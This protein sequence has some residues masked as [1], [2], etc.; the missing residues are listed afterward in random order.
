[1]NDL[2]TTN[3]AKVLGKTSLNWHSQCRLTPKYNPAKNVNQSLFTNVKGKLAHR[4]KGNH[5]SGV[6]LSVNFCIGIVS[7]RFFRDVMGREKGIPRVDSTA[8][9]T[10][11]CSSLYVLIFS[12]QSYHKE[13]VM[14]KSPTLAA[15]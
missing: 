9:D 10:G 12:P 7:A 5:I 8:I 14:Q 4:H 13:K 1:M 15:F 3:N 6:N 11:L 2:A